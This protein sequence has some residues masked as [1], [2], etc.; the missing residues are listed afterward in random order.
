VTLTL[1]IRRKL[2]VQ[3]EDAWN[4]LPTYLTVPASEVWARGR[5]ADKVDSLYMIRLIYLQAVFL[6]EWAATIHGTADI[7]ALYIISGDL[8]AWVNE[9]MIRRERLNMLGLSSLAWRVSLLQKFTF[10]VYICEFN[11]D[12]SRSLHADCPP[13][14]LWRGA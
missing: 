12:S 13:L 1:E 4:S 7:D 10:V 3:I 2:R 9:A 8:L 11:T 6:V 14:G 5:S